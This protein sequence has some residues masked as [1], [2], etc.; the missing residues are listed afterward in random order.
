[1]AGLLDVF[2]SE[3]GRMGLGLLGGGFGQQLRQG[4]ES[5]D[6][7]KK[8]Q[9]IA[10]IQ[11]LQMQKAQAEMA[12]AQAQRDE[13]RTEM[14]RQEKIRSGMG[15]FFTPGQPAL[16][17]LMGDPESG[18]L[19]SAGR[20]AQ[21]PSFDAGGAAQFLAQQ[22]EYEKALPM[23]ASL[24]PKSEKLRAGEAVFEGGKKLYENPK[25]KTQ[26]SAVQEYQFAQG[27]GYKGSFVDFQLDQKKAGPSKVGVDMRD[28]TAVA[29]AA[30]GFQN[31]YRAATK[32][33]YQRA[34][35]YE[36]MVQA[37][38]DPSAKGDLTMVYTFIKALD[39]SSVVREGEISLVNANRSIPDQIKGYAQKLA[40]GQNLLPAE[41]QDLINQARTLTQTDYKRSR[42]DVK[43]YRDNAQRLGLDPDM[44]APDPYA[45]FKPQVEKP[46][47]GKSPMKGQT[48]D[49]YKFKGGNPADPNS[50]ERQ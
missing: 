26:P 18:I 8:Q 4:V 23:L 32:D 19:P 10:Q 27:Q 20:P 15:Q 28:P 17:S 35:A 38:A 40:T 33:S 24:Q 37:S 12:D 50:W 48:V 30:M 41:R 31:D 36:S 44:Y 7:Y 9:M 34:Q 13:R 14:A 49:G 47:T 46:A 1:M 21:A 6:A 42:N 16:S 11:Q 43:A 45:G 39:P 29:K 25:E 2:N 3:Q 5:M 22:G